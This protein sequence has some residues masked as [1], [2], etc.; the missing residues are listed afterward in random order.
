MCRPYAGMLQSI[1]P[2]INWP[3]AFGM[4]TGESNLALASRNWIS[5]NFSMFHKQAT[6]LLKAFGCKVQVHVK[7]AICGKGDLTDQCEPVPVIAIKKVRGKLTCVSAIKNKQLSVHPE[8]VKSA[9]P[10]AYDT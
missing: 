6:I 7:R 9:R 8:F 10:C 3:H 1:L 2:A 4:A 5:P